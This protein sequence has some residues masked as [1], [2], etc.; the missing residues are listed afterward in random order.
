MIL[1]THIA[2]S[3]NISSRCIWD[4]P[5]ASK[6]SLLHPLCRVNTWVNG[7]VWTKISTF[8]MAEILRSHLEPGFRFLETRLPLVCSML[9]LMLSSC[10]VVDPIR[11]LSISIQKCCASRSSRSSRAQAT[12]HKHVAHQQADGIRWYPMVFRVILVA[13]CLHG[14]RVIECHLCPGRCE[15]YLRHGT[16]LGRQNGRWSGEHHNILKLIKICAT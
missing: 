2:T 10:R 15:R 16:R 6:T 14:D 1:F 12:V 4:P 3:T 11:S 7:Q 13:L 8:G 5:E 9:L